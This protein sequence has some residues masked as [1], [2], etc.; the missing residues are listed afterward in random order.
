MRQNPVSFKRKRKMKKRFVRMP[1]VLQL[2][3]YEHYFYVATKKV[4]TNKSCILRGSSLEDQVIGPMHSS[5]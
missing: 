2:I 4:E 1:W 3:A 5:L